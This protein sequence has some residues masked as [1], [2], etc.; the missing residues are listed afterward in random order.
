MIRTKM[1]NEKYFKIYKEIKDGNRSGQ[2]KII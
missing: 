2:F 1:E